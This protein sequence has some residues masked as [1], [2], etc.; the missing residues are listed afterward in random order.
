MKGCVYLQGA[1]PVQRYLAHGAFRQLCAEHDVTF[2]VQQS[3]DIVT[4]KLVRAH[5]P[6]P[7]GELAWVPFRTERF[8]VWADLF[9]ISCIRYRRRSPSFEIRYRESRQAAPERFAKY[10]RLAEP[11]QYEKHLVETDRRLG[12]HPELEATLRK[13][14]PEFIV[15]PSLL[16][17]SGTDDLLQAAHALGIQVLLLQTGWDN[18]CS[19]GLLVRLPTLMG[20]WGAQSAEHAASVQNMPEGRIRVVGAPHF[21]A[22][23]GCRQTRD[24]QL[25][26]ELGISPDKKAFLFAGTLRYFDETSLLQDIDMRIQRGDLPPMKIVYRPHPWRLRRESEVNFFDVEW[27]NV[28]MDPERRDSYETTKK[29]ATTITSKHRT[30]SMHYLARLYS[31]LDAVITPMSSI[32]LEAPTAGLP[33]M[34][35]AFGDGKHSWSADKVAGM[36]HFKEWFEL[37]GMLVSRSLDTFFDDLDEL[38]SRT[39]QPDMA[40][41]L[42]KA[43]LPLAWT[44]G[45]L[46]GEHVLSCV[47][48][49][50][51]MET[52]FPDTKAQ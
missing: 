18:L 24:S 9:N 21:D 7:V 1:D 20:V 27:D 22:F 14:A 2:V 48:E 8:K 38:L 39:G 23:K 45:Q 35:T 16:L 32:L 43:V 5:A 30:F 33:V 25:A 41:R 34:A 29:K 52:L 46:Y 6:H 15:L 51:D 31:V 11:G 47:N 13:L 49:L 44:D 4:E 3:S 28:V 36:M 10:E 19:K 50:S 26:K 17:D 12:L 37:D 42:R 40:D